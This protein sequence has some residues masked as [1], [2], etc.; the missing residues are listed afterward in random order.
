MTVKQQTASRKQFFNEFKL[1]W[2]LCVA[3]NQPA[4][5]LEGGEAD[6]KM[7][8]TKPASPNWPHTMEESAES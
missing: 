7:Q 1:R 4:V 6:P 2:H 5:I 3:P 8:N